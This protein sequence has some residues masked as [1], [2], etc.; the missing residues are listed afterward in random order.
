ME[1]M[2]MI[3]KSNLPR[4][5]AVQWG[6]GSTTM[7]SQIIVF[8]E[9][10]GRE[11]SNREIDY[12]DLF[13][14]DADR[15]CGIAFDKKLTGRAGAMHPEL[16]RTDLGIYEYLCRLIQYVSD[17][18]SCR[19]VVVDVNGAEED[20]IETV[21]SLLEDYAYIYA[22]TIRLHMHTLRSRGILDTVFSKVSELMRQKGCFQRFQY[23]LN[24][25][26][27]DRLEYERLASYTAP[28][29]VLCADNSCGGVL[30]QVEDDLAEALEENGQTVLRLGEGAA[31]SDYIN[32]MLVKAI[33]GFQ[34]KSLELP[35]FKQMCAAKFQ[36]C[37][38]HPLFFDD[39]LY[40]L[41]ED[42]YVLCQDE[43]F[44]GLIQ[45]YYHTVNAISFP[46]GGKEIVFYEGNR[47]YDVVFADAYFAED[48]A[49]LSDEQKAFYD[50][51]KQHPTFSFERGYA[52]MMNIPMDEITDLQQRMSELR[53]SCRAVI[54]YFRN[55]V[56]STILDAGITL[57]VYGESWKSSP[58]VDYPNLILHP[59]VAAKES[60][61]EFQKAKIGLNIM[62]WNKAGMTERVAEIMLAGAVCLSDETTYL[63]EHTKD[64][65]E[66]VLYKLTE[67]EKLPNCI[68]L[69]LDNLAKRTSIARMGYDKAVHEF[70]WKVKAQQLIVLT[71][72]SL[73]QEETLRIFVATHVAFQPPQNPIY[74]PLHVGRSGKQDL[75]YIGDNIGENISDLNY[76]YG[77]LTGLYWIWQN[78]EGI[79]YVGL[80]HYRRYFMNEKM[81]EMSQAE[82]L[83]YLHDYD[84]IVPKAMECPNGITYYEHFSKA[85]NHQDLDAV[86]WALKRVYP[87][88]ADAYD[89]AMQGHIFY[90]GNLVVTSLSILKA[91][92][93]WLFTIFVEAGERIDVSGY[94]AYHRRIYGFLSE[95]MFYVFAMANHLRLCEIAVGIAGE[96]AETL[97][98]K[99]QLKDLMDEGKYQEARAL[100]ERRMKERPDLLLEGSDINHE[101]RDICVR[102]EGIL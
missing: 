73:K 36:F 69:L 98:L 92:A 41:P 90:W 48:I 45:N 8:Y 102:L 71:E 9:D 29:L 99:N 7:G 44:I 68:L 3:V 81:H 94:D 2:E 35:I 86:E 64:G 62:D 57:H 25:F 5:V 79:K 40:N 20:C 10:I 87:E 93:E 42:Y 15:I 38:D 96:K 50:F 85:H 72:E 39:I 23:Y 34:A 46:P 19:L 55:K 65:E 67:L 60:V 88:Y 12:V 78:V 18:G 59:Q 37:F 30:Q 66:I 11:Y 4:T 89:H 21:G 70:S 33:I 95:Q 53:A 97:N 26:L 80:C 17:T 77:E 75:G 82:Y 54:G 56:F 1:T 58:F 31:T 52:E 27:A 83:Y 28:F 13:S 47:P 6:Q 61:L 84:A 101:L 49:E 22:Y 74:I 76:L 24:F 51:M 32:R 63:R 43:D 16:S 14:I 91:Y 100:L